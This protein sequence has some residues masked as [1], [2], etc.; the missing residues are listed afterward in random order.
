MDKYTFINDPLDY[1]DEQ[2]E[3]AE[4]RLERLKAWREELETEM[5]HKALQRY[6]EEKHE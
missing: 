1:L 2:I 3:L 5:A 6:M 4:A